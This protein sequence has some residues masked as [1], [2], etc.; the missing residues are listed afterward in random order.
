MVRRQKRCKRCLMEVRA[1]G[2]TVESL[3]A[4]T[5]FMGEQASEAVKSCGS[6]G[7]LSPIRQRNHSEQPAHLQLDLVAEPGT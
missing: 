7:V 2:N 6:G 4:K 1:S 3:R 5:M